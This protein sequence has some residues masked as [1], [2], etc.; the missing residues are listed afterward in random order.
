MSDPLEYHVRSILEIVGEDIYR[1]GLQ[2]TPGRVSRMYRDIFRGL[3]EDPSIHLHKQFLTSSNSMVVIR[4]IPFHTVC[5]HHLVPFVGT[6]HVGYIPGPSPEDFSQYRVAGLSKFARV[7]DSFAA[8]PQV[9]ETLTHQVAECIWETL[10]PQGVIVVMK[11][12]HMCMSMRGVKKSGTSTVTSSVR[13]VFDTNTDGV[14]DE[15]MSA[16]TL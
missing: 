6:A 15:F 4:D 7:I 5:E 8:R 1:D 13:G 3:K 11:A 9:Q 2:D 12:E 14:K 10:V 16:I